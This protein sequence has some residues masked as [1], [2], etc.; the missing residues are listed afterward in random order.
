M[1]EAIVNYAHVA[2]AYSHELYLMYAGVV[3]LR[4]SHSQL[5]PLRK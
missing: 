1:F 5:Y 2:I 4:F 3:M